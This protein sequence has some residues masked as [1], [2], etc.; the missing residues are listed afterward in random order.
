MG[1]PSTLLA[2]HLGLLSTLLPFQ[3]AL[4][5][6]IPTQG[7]ALGYVLV[8]PSGRALNA[9]CRDGAGLERSWLLINAFALS[10]RTSSPRSTQG[11]AL[12]YGLVAPSGRALNARCRDVGEP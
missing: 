3:G 4:Y 7:D 11:V 8:A 9:C 12:G 2:C 1:L 10:G 6:L 5:R